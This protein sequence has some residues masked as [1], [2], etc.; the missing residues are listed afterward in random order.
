LSI[1]RSQRYHADNIRVALAT[2]AV[3]GIRWLLLLSAALRLASIFVILSFLHPQT[4]EF[5]DVAHSLLRGHGYSYFGSPSAYMP[6]AYP[7]LLAGLFDLLGESWAVY[8]FLE[9][10]QAAAGVLLVFMVYRLA[11]VLYRDQ[12][13]ARLAAI[14]AALYPPF[15]EM[16]NEFHSINFYIVLGVAT[17]LFLAKTLQQPS[18]W[19]YLVYAAI[20]MGI[21][22]LF[23]AE[24]LL[25]AL[26]F[27][28]LLFLRSQ[29]DSRLA[30]SL[31]FL[32]IA[33]T[34]LA[35]WM[36]RNYRLFHELVPST[37]ASGINLYTGNNPNATGSDRS[38][39]GYVL[40]SVPPAM[41]AD[42]E[43]VPMVPEKE[44]LLDRIFRRE[45]FSYI[46]SHPWREVILA[47]QKLRIFWSF[48]P[49]HQKG[50][51]PVFWVPSIALSVF[52][53]VGLLIGAKSSLRELSPLLLSIAFAMLT[54]VVFFVLP[55]YKI[56]IDPF[57]C[58]FASNA[59]IS[60]QA[61]LCAWMP[62][63]GPKEHLN[64][65]ATIGGVKMLEHA[66]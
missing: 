62:G 37:T 38:A 42:L 51:Q 43:A 24:T 14:L 16:C 64:A 6:P 15:I 39:T 41:Q 29:R 19:D 1:A 10:V 8:L 31:V 32:G 12:A 7:L 58:I 40:S 22:L 61:N 13:L 28:A 5:G 9:V 21:L 65:N 47:G 45:A 57:L 66:A 25:L 2:S 53:A 3:F 52:A 55:R 59:V 34:L 4:W 63:R 30:R 35:P 54:S 56:A 20:S 44:L 27:A 50:A 46:A 18:R 36:L 23:R 11:L 33:Y 49:N 26:L 48:D 17:A 60:L